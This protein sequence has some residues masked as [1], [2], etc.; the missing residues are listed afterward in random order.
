VV[1]LG[2]TA[3][4]TIRQAAKQSAID[5]FDFTAESGS[6]HAQALIN[7]MSTLNAFL[8]HDIR[9]SGLVDP[10]TSEL[11]TDTS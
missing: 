1:S 5:E 4:R 8:C 3:R 10:T 6:E 11:F 7:Q 9:Q 2:G